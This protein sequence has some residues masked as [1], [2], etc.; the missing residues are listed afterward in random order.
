MRTHHEVEKY[1]SCRI[2]IIEMRPGE[3]KEDAWSRHLGW[4]P[5]DF[6]ADIKIFS[7]D[8]RPSRHLKEQRA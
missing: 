4:Y 7:R 1:F 6:Y 2:A 3:T 5:E 8:S